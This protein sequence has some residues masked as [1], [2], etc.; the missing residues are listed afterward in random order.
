MK[1]GFK[2]FLIKTGIFSVIFVILSII[3][4]PMIV[5]SR[6]LNDFYFF[7]YGGLGKILLFAV[8]AFLILSRRKLLRLRKYEPNYLF[9]IVS[10]VFG[11]IFYLLGRYAAS[12]EVNLFLLHIIFLLTFIF[13]GL[14]VYSWNFF[15]DFALRFRKELITIGVMSVVFY[16]LMFFVWQL[17]TQLSWLVSRIVFFLLD[18]TTSR[19]ILIEPYTVGVGS[20]IALIDQACSGVYSMFLFISLYLLILFFD[21]N[22]IEKWK[23]ALLFP[24]IV[25]GLFFV[26]VIRIYLLYIV[27]Y[28][29]SPKLAI[30]LFHSYAGMVLF[31]LYFIA[32]WYFVE[33]W[34]RKG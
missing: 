20:F 11:V 30:G 31:I 3:F 8:I 2:D 24:F 28:L 1:A 12:N 32:V 9:G 22:R 15:R 34:V 27:G 29:I 21:W 4:G 10:I 23:Y 18:L 5:H 25:V 13:L 19:A 7:I 26:N 6:L 33:P 17:W 14:A 16:I